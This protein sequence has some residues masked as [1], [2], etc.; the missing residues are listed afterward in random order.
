MAI[1]KDGQTKLIIPNVNDAFHNDGVSDRWDG[2]EEVANHEFGPI[3]DANLIQMLCCGLSAARQ[4][5]NGCSEEC[6]Y[7]L[8]TA[9]MSSPEPPPISMR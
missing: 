3:T 6:G 9:P 4:I 5:K 1:S 2:S 8:A 7:C